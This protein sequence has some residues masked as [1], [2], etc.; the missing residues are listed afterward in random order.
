[1]SVDPLKSHA[2]PDEAGAVPKG[3]LSAER[4]HTILRRLNDGFYDAA[5][6]RTL[7]ARRVALDIGNSRPE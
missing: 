2:C 3:T 1:M 6:V 7:V 4:M 5:E